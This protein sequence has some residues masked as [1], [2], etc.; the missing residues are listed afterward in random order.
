MKTHDRKIKV[1]VKRKRNK[2]AEKT[3]VRKAGEPKG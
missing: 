3:K 2:Q 1:Q